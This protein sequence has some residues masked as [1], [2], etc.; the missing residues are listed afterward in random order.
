A[1]KRKKD[2]RQTS[3]AIIIQQSVEEMSH[4][5]P[6]EMTEKCP[7]KKTKSI[8]LKQNIKDINIRK[9]DDI[10][11]FQHDSDFIDYRVPQSMRMK[12]ATAFHS[13]V[14]N[15][16][17]HNAINIAKKAA[18]KCSLLADTDIFNNILANASVALYA[19]TQEFE[20]N[21]TLMKN[22]I[23]Y[24]TRTFKKMV[25]NYVDSFRDIHN[26]AQR[27]ANACIGGIYY[28]WLKDNDSK[29]AST[30]TIDSSL[31]PGVYYK[32]SKEEADEMGL[33]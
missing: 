19:K 27:K 31:V 24:F 23:G 18:K 11:S 6:A 7:T 32:I 33:Y 1:M 29:E 13:K 16:S 10:Q 30:D 15:E 22:P 8:S 17:F 5:T 9:E 21:G 4:K 2:M 20:H 28:N 14:I 12:L 26:V 3:N 25:Y